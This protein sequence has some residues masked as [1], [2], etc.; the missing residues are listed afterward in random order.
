MIE[1]DTADGQ[2]YIVDTYHEACTQFGKRAIK[3]KQWPTGDEF[4]SSTFVF[5]DKIVAFRFKD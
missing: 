2:K 4:D 5:M 1:I 3:V